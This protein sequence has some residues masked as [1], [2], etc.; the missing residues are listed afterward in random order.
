MKLVRLF[1]QI[2]EGR[3][4]DWDVPEI[5]GETPSSPCRLELRD[6]EFFHPYITSVSMHPRALSHEVDMSQPFSAVPSLSCPR[7]HSTRVITHDYAR[8]AGSVVGGVAGAGG[9][10]AAAMAGAQ[11]GAVMGA[12]AGPPGA[13]VGG[14]AGAVMGALIGAVA[15]STAGGA[16]GEV[17]DDTV[18]DNFECKDCGHTFGHK[19]LSQG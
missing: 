8:T 10:A 7:C 5:G 15:G 2:G 17:I 1:Y 9:A 3:R 4:A 13:F 16:V 6:S 19:K 11:T 12:F 18:L 14:I